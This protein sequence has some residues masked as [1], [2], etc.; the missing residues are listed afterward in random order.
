MDA[1]HERGEQRVR[2]VAGRNQSVAQL[3]DDR[4]EAFGDERVEQLL[5]ASEVVVQKGRRYAGLQC[6][7]ALAG[8]GHA[9]R[10][11]AGDGG[12]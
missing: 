3:A 8:R 5:L 10:G 12:V 1:A 9:V 4:R 11:E 2:V 6:D 7:A